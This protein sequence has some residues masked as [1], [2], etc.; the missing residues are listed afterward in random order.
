MQGVRV[1]K[2][3]K[4]MESLVEWDVEAE[5]LDDI[6]KNSNYHDISQSVC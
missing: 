6:S 5:C 2:K 3:E 1:E 4:E